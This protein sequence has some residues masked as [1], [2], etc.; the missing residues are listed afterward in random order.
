MPEEIACAQEEFI[1]VAFKA[2]AARADCQDGSGESLRL[3]VKRDGVQAED[4]AGLQQ[5]L[6]LAFERRDHLG[7]QEALA[8]G[9]SAILRGR[10]GLTPL[11]H[12][13]QR[14]DSDCAKALA[15]SSDL[16]AKDPRYKT[17]LMMAAD[18]GDAACVEILA[19]PASCRARMFDGATALALAAREC[20]APCIEMLL[21]WSDP[22]CADWDGLTPLMEVA[23]RGF[24]EGVLLLAPR[25]DVDALDASGKT[26]LDW[27]LHGQHAEVADYLSAMSL[28][29]GE[30]RE[31]RSASLFAEAPSSVAIASTRRAL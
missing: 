1:G 29:R 12:A 15:P 28:S 6:W 11:M 9:A 27:A 20:S 3:G 17:A 26:A 30:L 8:A 13:V 31:L 7:A 4:V 21:K 24:Q 14:R 23:M 25:S 10:Y 19:D 2:D 18:N 5:R 22:D 16:A